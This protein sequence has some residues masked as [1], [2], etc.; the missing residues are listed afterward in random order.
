LRLSLIGVLAACG[1]GSAWIIVLYLRGEGSSATFTSGAIR[2]TDVTFLPAMLGSIWALV[3]LPHC[4]S[5]LERA[6]VALL[7]VVSLTGLFFTLQRGAWLA[8]LL[9]SIV[10][11]ILMTPARRARLVVAAV[12]VGGGLV[13]AILVFNAFSAARVDNPLADGLERLQS[14]QA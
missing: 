13:A 5:R 12:V 7:A 9:G 3:L 6:C 8:F 2:I 4:R 10:A 11:A 1:V 14:V